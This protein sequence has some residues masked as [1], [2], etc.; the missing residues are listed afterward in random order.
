MQIFKFLILFSLMA[1][2]LDIVSA[3]QVAFD[4]LASQDVTPVVSGNVIEAFSSNTLKIL[5][6]LKVKVPVHSRKEIYEFEKLHF[7]SFNPQIVQ[8]SLIC[9]GRV[10]EV[11]AR[12]RK[13]GDSLLIPIKPSDLPQGRVN[14]IIIEDSKHLFILSK[15]EING[16][17]AFAVMKSSE[18]VLES[19]G[20]YTIKDESFVSYTGQEKAPTT[21]DVVISDTHNL[22]LNKKGEV[23]NAT[24]GYGISK[25]SQDDSD[26][27]RIDLSI[28]GDKENNYTVKEDFNYQKSLN[29]NIDING[30]LNLS[31]KN[32]INTTN[33]GQRIVFTPTENISLY[34]E[35]SFGIELENND[36]TSSNLIGVELTHEDSSLVVESLENYSNSKL[37]SKNIDVSVSNPIIS[38]SHSHTIEFDPV[39][40]PVNKNDTFSAQVNLTDETNLRVE[41]GNSRELNED[42]SSR[43]NAVGIS[44]NIDGTEVSF[45]NRRTV[46]LDYGDQTV[47][48]ELNVALTRDSFSGSYTHTREVGP[49]I[50]L[51]A[52]IV[53]LSF[54]DQDGRSYSVMFSKETD[55]LEDMSTYSGEL[56]MK[57]RQSL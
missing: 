35:S 53:D 20:Y 17:E 1:L 42:I 21:N 7:L 23:E 30:S 33:V 2:T 4:P 25:K 38:G 48:D 34:E 29:E 18:G 31:Q 24:I 55:K 51:Y 32:E 44:T 11:E 57:S 28:F 39:D 46:D 37:E 12:K 54:L 50:N 45:D 52:D 36:T 47:S 22:N 3:G 16:I 6:R 41:K 13:N 15:V 26:E 5:E 27:L 56:A 43:T 49:D 9:G 19:I 40:G 10:D 8:Y 14:E